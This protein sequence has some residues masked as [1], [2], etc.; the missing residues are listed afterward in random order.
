[1]IR[2]AV[3][4]TGIAYRVDGPAD[5]PVIVFINS[6]GTDHRMWDWQL[7]AFVDRFRVVR[8][9]ACGHG[10]AGARHGSVT[11]D[12]LGQDLILLLDHL[13]IDRAHLCGCSL[14]GMLTLWT[15]AHYPARVNRAVVANS[16]AKIGTAEGW[17]ARIA[18]VRQGGM[19]G[20]RDLTLGRFFSER[21]RSQHADAVQRISEILGGIDPV[22]Y[23]A[24]CQALRNADLRAIVSSIRTPTLIV[25][26]ELDVATPRQLQ[27]EL[28]AAIP[29][30]QLFVIAQA[31]HLSNIEQ[32]DV[33]N[34][35]VLRFLEAQP[36]D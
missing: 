30:S 17:D 27:E 2:G 18:A 34:E 23:I 13:A 12:V 8:Y 21:F 16:G 9:D 19:A 28:H 14:G 32:P 20:A 25:A 22:G 7:P 24:A 26:G 10:A 11:I 3:A 36:S 5:A 4:D 6:L 31:A 29:E 35:R 1:M 33:F 15:A